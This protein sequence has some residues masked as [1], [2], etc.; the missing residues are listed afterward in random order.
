MFHCACS[1]TE[2]QLGQSDPG[3]AAASGG[4]LS[5]GI[6]LWDTRDWR[7]FLTGSWRHHGSW[8]QRGLCHQPGLSVCHTVSITGSW[9]IALYIYQTVEAMVHF[10]RT[11]HHTAHQ[12]LFV[13]LLPVCFFLTSEV[14]EADFHATMIP[15]LIGTHTAGCSGE[16]RLVLHIPSSSWAGNR[17]N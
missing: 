14:I 9:K 13:S 8:Q 7:D 6:R 3:W 16:T 5:C 1:W 12:S 11:C 17:F 4:N 2:Q 10:V 15:S